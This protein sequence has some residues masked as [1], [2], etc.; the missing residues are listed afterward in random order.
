MNPIDVIQTVVLAI[1][2]GVIAWYTYETRKIWKETSKQNT[3]LAEQLRIMQ[4]S[5]L[6]TVAEQQLDLQRTMSFIQPL[7]R[8]EGGEQSA[9]FAK[10][11]FVNKGGPAR[12]LKIIP[13][14]NFNATIQPN[15][16][17]GTDEK[18]KVEFTASDLKVQ[19]RLDFEIQ[20]QDKLDQ[21]LKKKF[22]FL[23]KTGLAYEDDN[24]T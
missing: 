6:H 9:Q 7:F 14:G 2:A 20:Y 17:I 19:K 12:K 5:Y 24:S 13:V 23:Y 18:G 10:I 21:T 15:T 3:L 11:Q 22:Y 4:Q 16:V 8:F 1:T